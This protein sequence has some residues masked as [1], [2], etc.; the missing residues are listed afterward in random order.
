MPRH[1]ATYDIL[2]PYARQFWPHQLRRTEEDRYSIL[3]TEARAAH[4]AR[5][6]LGE[7]EKEQDAPETIRL[8]RLTPAHARALSCF[9][10]SSMEII[11][12]F[13]PQV[14]PPTSPERLA[15]YFSRLA[16]LRSLR[17]REP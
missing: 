2:T 16:L 15:Q 4:A 7:E 1:P 12:L 6:I 17:D 14:C 10:S 9:G 11:M 8:S 5:S 13:E 3:N